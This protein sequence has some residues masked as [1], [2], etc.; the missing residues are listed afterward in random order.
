MIKHVF[1]TILALWISIGNCQSTAST[2]I[3]R[4]NLQSNEL[5]TEKGIW[6]Y[7]PE[8]YS[9]DNTSYPVVYMF[10]GQNLFDNETSFVGE[11]K[12]DEFLD[13]KNA[14][15]IVVGIE[16]GNEKRI[17]ELTP[18]P[19][20]KHGGGKADS[21]LSFL[22]EN[23]KP[24]IDSTYRTLPDLRHTSIAGSS[25]GGLT[26]F[27]ALL[28]YPDVFGNAGVFSPS[29]WINPEIYD[30][31][32]SSDISKK[33]KFYFAAGTKEGETMIPNLEKMI[34]TLSEKGIELYKL[35]TDI[36][37]GAEH[38]EAFWSA[39]FPKFMDW[40]MAQMA[41]KTFHTN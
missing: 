41:A 19:S 27:Y 38:N 32:K 3:V 15:I 18:F 26:S 17:E 36:V 4:L 16:H 8:S 39:E 5:E 1:I 25:L 35:E 28:K 31:V 24:H 7:L 20:E 13:S 12:I 23:L 30:L 2:N 11:W 14:N 37:E 29:F 40:L 21:M 6:V 33:A 10:D 34:S 22:V 9:N